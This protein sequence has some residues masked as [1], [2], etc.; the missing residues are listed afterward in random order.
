MTTAQP[1]PS[2]PPS[3]PCAPR[4]TALHRTSCS[5]CPSPVDLNVVGEISQDI[6][7]F[8]LLISDLV[9]QTPQLF[10]QLRLPIIFPCHNYF[11][12]IQVPFM[13]KIDMCQK[14]LKMTNKAPGHL[15]QQ[16]IQGG[17]F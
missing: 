11:G 13:A 15:E 7:I 10:F 9:T 16:I 5:A 6:H 4:I 17:F 2:R 14:S 1:P 8:F 12:H 3:A